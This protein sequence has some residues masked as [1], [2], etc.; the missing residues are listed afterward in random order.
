MQLICNYKRI[1]TILDRNNIGIGCFVEQYAKTPLKNG[2]N[3]KII[4]ETQKI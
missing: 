3:V 4:I 2:N 1:E